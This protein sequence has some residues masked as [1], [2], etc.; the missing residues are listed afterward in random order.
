M[1]TISFINSSKLV[2]HLLSHSPQ[3]E[4]EDSY[5]DEDLQFSTFRSDDYRFY[6]HTFSQHHEL[7]NSIDDSLLDIRKEEDS[8]EEDPVCYFK[9]RLS[10]HSTVESMQSLRPLSFKNSASTIRAILAKDSSGESLPKV[11]RLNFRNKRMA[12]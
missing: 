1:K 6:D 7:Y 4:Q 10:S 8:L 3:H 2:H 12:L 9:N 5:Y 11:G